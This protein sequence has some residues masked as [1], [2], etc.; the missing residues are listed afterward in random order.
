MIS[1]SE[2]AMIERLKAAIEQDIMTATKLHTPI[3]LKWTFVVDDSS[4]WILIDVDG[5]EPY[6]IDSRLPRH[7]GMWRETRDIYRVVN[8]Q[9]L[10]DAVLTE[11]M[12]EHGP[13]LS[14]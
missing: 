10:E 2:M 7:F 11:A 9:V 3:R 12:K 1:A 13:V 5:A 14:G 8:H 4:P 6:D